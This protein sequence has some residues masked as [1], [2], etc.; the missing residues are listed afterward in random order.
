M[1]IAKME[2]DMQDLFDDLNCTQQRHFIQQNLDAM[3]ID[4]ITDYLRDNGY[5]VTKRYND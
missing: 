5:E 1:I 4:D 3:F 2:I